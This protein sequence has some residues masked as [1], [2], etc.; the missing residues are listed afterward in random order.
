M[1]SDRI[2]ESC[3]GAYFASQVRDYM[4]VGK[5]APSEEDYER[6]AEEAHSVACYGSD[7]LEGVVAEEEEAI[8]YS[9]EQAQELC[10]KLV[11]LSEER[12][13]D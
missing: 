7:F 9:D 4:R 11:R 2:Y 1:N 8:T 13:N 3:Y 5:G 6:F 12:Q 10:T